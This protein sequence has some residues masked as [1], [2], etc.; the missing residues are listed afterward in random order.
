LAFEP[1][2]VG[3]KPSCRAAQRRRQS[4][5]RAD[6]PYSRWLLLALAA[7]ALL[8]LVRFGGAVV[9]RAAIPVAL[10]GLAVY[11]IGRYGRREGWW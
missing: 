11:A 2:R 1:L 6:D 7:I 3:G 8:L 4:Q 5:S 10:A 9:L